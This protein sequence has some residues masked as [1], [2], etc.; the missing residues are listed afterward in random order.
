LRATD[1]QVEQ[2]RERD[3]LERT[4]TAVARRINRGDEEHAR[5][6][7]RMMEENVMLMTQISELRR[8]SENLV[9][10][11]RLLEE[12]STTTSTAEELNTIREMQ[13]D[14]IE[15]L[16]QQFR[17]NISRRVPANECNR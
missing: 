13:K 5:Q 9:K 3:A 16:K 12:S 7:S 14:M 11:Q 10:M 15:Q 6:H 17:G 8:W 4:M 1:I 2:N